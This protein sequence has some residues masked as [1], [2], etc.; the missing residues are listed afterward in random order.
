MQLCRLIKYSEFSLSSIL[1][2]FLTFRSTKTRNIETIMSITA[3]FK[4][5]SFYPQIRRKY[6]TLIDWFSFVGGILGLF[7]G[8]SFLSAFEIIFH[9]WMLTFGGKSNRFRNDQRIVWIQKE[10]DGKLS[11]TLK[12]LKLFMRSSSIHGLKYIP[13]GN[14]KLLER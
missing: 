2:L 13:S 14:V 1:I 8:F 4:D 11:K 6:F 3:K 10:T 7:F 5:D 12:Y 9:A